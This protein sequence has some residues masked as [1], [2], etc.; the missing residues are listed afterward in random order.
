MILDQIYRLVGISNKKNPQKR[1]TVFDRM[2][3]EIKKEFYEKALE[4][5][6]DDSTI[7]NGYVFKN[8]KLSILQKMRE[9]MVKEYVDKYTNIYGKKQTKDYV[10]TLS[11]LSDKDILQHYKLNNADLFPLEMDNNENFFKDKAFTFLKSR[12]INIPK[13]INIFK[14]RIAFNNEDINFLSGLKPKNK[15]DT[16]K[17]LVEH[18]IIVKTR[19][20]SCI[21]RIFVKELTYLIHLLNH[22]KIFNI[23]SFVEKYI[24]NTKKY[25]DKLSKDIIFLEMAKEKEYDPKTNNKEEVIKGLQNIIY[26]P[27]YIQGLVDNWET[28]E[29]YGDMITLGNINSNSFPIEKKQY[30]LGANEDIENYAKCVKYFSCQGICSS[31]PWFDVCD[32]SI[33][34]S[35]Y[36]NVIFLFSAIYNGSNDGFVRFVMKNGSVVPKKKL[37]TNDI[38]KEIIGFLQIKFKDDSLKKNNRSE[39]ING[40][41]S[42]YLFFVE[43]KKSKDIYNVISS[44]Y[45]LIDPY[46]FPISNCTLFK[47]PSLSYLQFNYMTKYAE[48]DIY[49][50]IKNRN[51]YFLHRKDTILSKPPIQYGIEKVIYQII[52]IPTRINRDGILV[53]FD[54]NSFNITIDDKPISFIELVNEWEKYINYDFDIL[55]NQLII[56]SNEIGFPSSNLD[57]LNNKLIYRHIFVYI[58]TD[59][60]II[61]NYWLKY[62]TSNKQYVKLIEEGGKKIF[63]VSD[64]EIIDYGVIKYLK[65]KYLSNDFIVGGRRKTVSNNYSFKIDSNLIMDQLEYD[66]NKKNFE[67]NFADFLKNIS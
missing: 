37:T 5:A 2:S 4:F 55:E 8:D 66:V 53:P 61:N 24:E 52:R 13:C 29:Y 21:N 36:L 30:V 32:Y 48:F 26:G 10:Y 16:I 43:A 56:K 57:Y 39:V 31:L 60:D 42:L 25:N 22:D 40:K 1:E 14:K 20:N 54:H 65:K 63:F 19:E 15:F 34:Y 18:L 50:E 27:K 47:K 58:E 9:D 33:E 3:E 6:N 46:I 38:N 62:K 28:C 12:I 17:E 59:E 64:Y 41:N 67:Y 23:S 45:V 7:V 51:I 49:R 11:E 35:D 44:N